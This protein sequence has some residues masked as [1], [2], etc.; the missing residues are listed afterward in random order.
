[1]KAEADQSAKITNAAAGTGPVERETAPAFVT[2]DL[3]DDIS[4]EAALLM[5]G[6]PALRGEPASD[7]KSSA[8]AGVAFPGRPSTVSA[9]SSGRTFSG[10][11]L[12]GINS[13][14][15]G[16]S[17]DERLGRIILSG[18]LAVLLWFYVTGLENPAQL[19]SFR[20]LTV[21]MRGMEANLKAINTVPPVTVDV[22]FQAP[23][24]V[25]S[26]LESNDIRPYV[27]LSG[28]GGGV[29]RVLVQVDFRGG[30][31][32]S[33]SNLSVTPADIQ[34]QLEVQATRSF[35]VEASIVGTPAFGYELEQAQI[36]PG[37]VSVSGSESAI[38][39]IVSVI[40]TVDVADKVTTQRGLRS[41]VALDANGQEIAGL[42]FAPATVQVIVPIK[43]SLSNRLVPVRVPILDNP[44]P[45]YSVDDIKIEPTNVTLCCAPNN[46][47]EEVDSVSTNP[48]SIAG[49]TGSIVTTTTLILPAG[50]ELYPGQSNTVTVT[51]SV[52]TFDT[53]WQ[54][55]VSPVL[56]GL[57]EGF[58]AVVS[59]TSIDLTLSGT[60]AQFQALTPADVSATIDVTPLDAGTY[61]ITPVINIPADITL[62]SVNPPNVTLSIIAPTPVPPTPTS[63]PTTEPTPLPTF[64]AVE[65]TATETEVV[66]PTATATATEIANTP[67]T[68]VEA[69]PTPSETVPVETPTE[70]ATS[71]AATATPTDT[72]T[73]EPTPAT[74]EPTPLDTQE[75]VTPTPGVPSEIE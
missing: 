10:R 25:L 6:E 35:T 34:V 66:L 70:T 1:M 43:G 23:Q 71:E 41:P 27:N 16:L 44:A 47:L 54:I 29:H 75:I 22:S 11:L 33:L 52:Q 49:I 4:E 9:P 73:P 18:V 20:G 65:P 42:I 58:A 17:L 5:G 14:S 60:F 68:T 53:T 50:V 64:T 40:A 72:G 13:L 46:I 28:L 31:E 36:D 62:V 26:T 39:R 57:P 8:G 38:E 7:R 30:I 15:R 55:S 32:N 69:T 63:T 3:P 2:Q 45:G 48:V 67:T 51:V 59:P 19:T 12:V 74:P 37:V 61:E 21:E 24:N 56:Q